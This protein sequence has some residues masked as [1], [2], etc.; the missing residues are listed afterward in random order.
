MAKAQRKR[1]KKVS[2]GVHGGA[3]KARLNKSD[4]VLLGK[5]QYVTF[6]PIGSQGK[7]HIVKD[8]TSEA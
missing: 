4:L 2:A 3:R 5:G 6:K 7:S 1:D 8:W